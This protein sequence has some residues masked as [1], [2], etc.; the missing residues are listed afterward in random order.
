MEWQG[1]QIPQA[2]ASNL[3]DKLLKF[4]FVTAK[5]NNEEHLITFYERNPSRRGLYFIYS[6]DSKEYFLRYEIGR[7]HV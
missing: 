4:N 1:I 6:P 3:I 2:I 5:G 7:A